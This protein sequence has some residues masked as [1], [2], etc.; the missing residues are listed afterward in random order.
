MFSSMISYI[1]KIQ[2]ISIFGPVNI[3]CRGV[4]LDRADDNSLHPCG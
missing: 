2:I 4:G 1:I 3:E